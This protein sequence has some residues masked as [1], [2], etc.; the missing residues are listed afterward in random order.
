MT[1][2]LGDTASRLVWSRMIT[3]VGVGANCFEDVWTVH[4][5][6]GTRSSE[7]EWEIGLGERKELLETAVAGVGITEVECKDD[8]ESKVLL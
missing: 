5:Y 8:F 4:W 7:E 2:R 3:G 6:S 1:G